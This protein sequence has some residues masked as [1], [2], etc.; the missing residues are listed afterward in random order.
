MRYLTLSLLLALCW[1]VWSGQGS[2]F[3]IGA[4]LCSVLLTCWVA[5]RL[6]ISDRETRRLRVLVHTPRYWLWLLVEMARC[7]LRVMRLSISPGISLQPK[8]GWVITGLKDDLLLATYANSITLTPGTV[9]VDVN[10]KPSGSA[11]IYVHA[12]ESSSLEELRQ[13]GMEA[14][15]LGL[16]RGLPLPGMGGKTP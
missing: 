5:H 6:A 9:S 3:F 13:G 2:P 1:G 10:K 14:R 12:L 4:G 11:G 15:L 7:S 16:T 8:F